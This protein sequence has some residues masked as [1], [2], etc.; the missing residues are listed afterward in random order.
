MKFIQNDPSMARALMNNNKSAITNSMTSTFRVD[1]GYKPLHRPTTPM[2]NMS[3]TGTSLIY[4]NNNYKEN[5]YDNN[6]IKIPEDSAKAFMKK[7][8]IK[9]TPPR[10]YDK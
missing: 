3:M 2:S 1:D 4:K 6:K 9:R 10:N 7:D 8:K 5:E